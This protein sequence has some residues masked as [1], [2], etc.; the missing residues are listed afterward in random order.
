MRLHE[1][2]RNA[3]PSRS[4]PFFPLVPSRSYAAAAAI[5]RAGAARAVVGV[6][7]LLLEDKDFL[8]EKT[9]Y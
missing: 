8:C 3:P 9:K 7:S 6:D 1:R 2:K 5:D 4:F